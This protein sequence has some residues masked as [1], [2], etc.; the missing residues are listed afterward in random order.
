MLSPRLHDFL[1]EFDDKVSVLGSDIDE[2]LDVLLDEWVDVAFALKLLFQ[3][4]DLCNDDDV[5]F[6][7]FLLGSGF[8]NLCPYF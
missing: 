7:S 2:L 3:W 8:K 4:N 6:H 5:T 1:F